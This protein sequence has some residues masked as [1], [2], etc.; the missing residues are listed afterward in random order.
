VKKSQWTEF[1]LITALFCC[2]VMVFIL[3]RKEYPCTLSGCGCQDVWEMLSDT[4]P[5]LQLTVG[6]LLYVWYLFHF[7]HEA[8]D[9]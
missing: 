8:F 4:W 5:G 6:V 3:Y 7:L 9:V 1:L 2:S